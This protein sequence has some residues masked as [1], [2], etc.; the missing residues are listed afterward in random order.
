MKKYRNYLILLNLLIVLMIFN[1]SVVDKENTLDK[2]DLVLL[3]LAPVDPRSLMQGDYMRLDYEIIEK[4]QSK[5]HSKRG[6][7]VVEL[8]V[9]GV[10]KLI[11]IQPK[12][13]PKQE[14]ELLIEYTS[15]GSRYEFKIGAESFFF[16]EGTSKKYE[17]AQYGG[18]RLNKNGKSVLV[19]LYNENLIP[20]K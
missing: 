18:L 12:L 9:S 8:D 5:R 20:I 4:I 16:Q 19:G 6:F 10:A 1:L 3:K 14:K 17:S 15:D 13:K 2:G 7:V 11:R